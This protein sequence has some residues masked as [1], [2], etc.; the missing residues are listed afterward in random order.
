MQLLSMQLRLTA[1]IAFLFTG[2]ATSAQATIIVN[3]SE[4][5]G[6][7]VFSTEPGGSLNR[8]EWTGL[9]N[10]FDIGSVD[11]DDLILLGGPGSAATDR[12]ITPPAS[13]TGPMSIGTG[14]TFF[15][16]NTGSGD[17]F[18][19]LF[20]ASGGPTLV[21]PD[22]YASGDPLSG[23]STYLGSTFASLG[24]TPDT[25]VWSWGSGGTADSFTLNVVPEPSTAAL[26]ALGL[27]GLAAR[28][29]RP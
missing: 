5:G 4:V 27:V 17:T 26:T 23:T 20:G 18:G 3:A 15:A 6:N 21:V 16:A 25:Y 11:A 29:R 7:V 24:L 9:Q 14:T 22:A 8:D 1:L 12:R 2:L 13:F 19:I 10:T 28:R